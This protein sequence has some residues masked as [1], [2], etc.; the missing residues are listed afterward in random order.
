MSYTPEQMQQ[1]ADRYL[2]SIQGRMANDA[3]GTTDAEV[4]AA[5]GP[6]VGGE[7]LVQWGLALR[8]AGFDIRPAAWVEQ[9]KRSKES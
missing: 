6:C 1:L 4:R 2:A 8:D 9:V 5:L 7:R 3:T